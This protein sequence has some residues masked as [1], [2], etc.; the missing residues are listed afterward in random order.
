MS[1]QQSHRNN[2]TQRKQEEKK[3]KKGQMEKYH[4]LWNDDLVLYM[5]HHLPSPMIPTLASV[6]STFQHLTKHPHLRRDLILIHPT[7][8]WTATCLLQFLHHY[9]RE[10]EYATHVHRVYL[11]NTSLDDA[12]LC[13]LLSYPLPNLSCM[14]IHIK[15]NQKNPNLPGLSGHAFPMIQQAPR[16]LH[17]FILS[18]DLNKTIKA[19]A[20][21]QNRNGRIG[22]QSA[23][24]PCKPLHTYLS[25]STLYHL[26]LWCPSF[27]LLP[28]QILAILQDH[29]LHH[30]S[31]SDCTFFSKQDFQGILHRFPRH[32]QGVCVVKK[33]W[34]YMELQRGQRRIVLT[35]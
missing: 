21:K 24:F 11:E 9:L 15:P 34:M 8:T 2:K 20:M 22:W 25:T 19:I 1:Q 10:G 23:V 35:S 29:K 13:T 12:T 28:S 3:K 26:E 4:A 33:P 14:E 16:S 27:A 17:T 18:Y 7:K 6:S 32:Q 5:L 30:V 31:L